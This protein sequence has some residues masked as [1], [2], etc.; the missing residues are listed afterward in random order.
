M[1][2]RLGKEFKNEF[3][4]P[5]S[6]KTRIDATICDKLCGEMRIIHTVEIQDAKDHD[7]TPPEWSNTIE[8]LL[9]KGARAWKKEHEK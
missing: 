9:R 8:M 6:S 5:P 4:F 1:A 3:E 2:K 7:R